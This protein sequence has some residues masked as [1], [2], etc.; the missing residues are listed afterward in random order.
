M[1]PTPRGSENHTDAP[2]R[3]KVTGY[4]RILLLGSEP[5]LGR[6]PLAT[7]NTYDCGAIWRSSSTIPA[8]RE[9]VLFLE[10]STV[11]PRGDW[12]RCTEM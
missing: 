8:G 1:R 2:A 5:F 7:R 12:E 4:G 9:I 11:A 3:S 10:T 6:C